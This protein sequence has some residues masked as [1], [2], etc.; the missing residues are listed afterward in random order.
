MRRPLPPKRRL[1][2]ALAVSS[3]TSVGLFA[4]GAW[5]NHSVAF[6]YLVWNLFL[7][8]LPLLFAVWLSRTLRTH[9]WSSWPALALTAAWV[10]FLPNSF[11]MISDFIHIQEVQR[12][13]LLYDVV[14]FAS[15][16]F[17]GVLLG[18]I[19]LYLVHYELE[20]RLRWRSAVAAIGWVLL[21]C[22]FA[23]YVGRELRWNTWDVLVNPAG[24]LVDVS[25]RLLNPHAYPHVVATTA[26]FF[27]VMA[28]LYVVTW[29]TAGALHQHTSGQLP[30]KQS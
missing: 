26:S 27:V 22:S 12:V 1:A 2:A 17:N 30:E 21:A 7:A 24:I 5:S 28:S 20:R 11:Y 23:I 15:F 25:N 10:G 8:W 29:Q 4:A 6:A 3:L 18:C 16:I 13:D 14:M 9:L 19:S